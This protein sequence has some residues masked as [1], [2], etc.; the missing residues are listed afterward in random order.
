MTVVLN[1]IGAS[2]S[3]LP[4]TVINSAALTSTSTSATSSSTLTSSSSSSVLPSQTSAAPVTKSS[5][6]TGAIVGG[7]VGGIVAVG[8]IVILALL[9]LR[10]SNNQR[11]ATPATFGPETSQRGGYD[12]MNTKPF[13]APQ[14]TGGSESN[15]FAA[16]T[17]PAM[18]FDHS[19]MG[20]LR[21]QSSIPGMGAPG[22]QYNIHAYSSGN[23]PDEMNRNTAYTASSALSSDPTYAE[24]P[25]SGQSFAPLLSTGMPPSVSDINRSSHYATDAPFL[26]G[27]NVSPGQYV[28]PAPPQSPPPILV[29]EKSPAPNMDV[30]EIAKEVASLLAPHLQG[31]AGKGAGLP[32]QD[33]IPSPA[34]Q[35]RPLP[36]PFPMAYESEIPQARS[37][38]PP[39][40]ERFN[41]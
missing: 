2:A 36:N 11:Q 28:S 14:G 7:V 33:N 34:S 26:V 23:I 1:G 16:G 18:P 20:H 22:M 38:G 17:I 9:L 35:K 21:N 5:S 24:P 40:Y 29:S 25:L 3:A 6:N 32:V 19:G 12:T 15:P 8:I 37:P 10:R 13:I 41:Q 39:Q 4:T 30:K 31:A 27:A